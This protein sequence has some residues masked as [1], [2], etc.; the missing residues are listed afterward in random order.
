MFLICLYRMMGYAKLRNGVSADRFDS[1]IRVW[2]RLWE[3]YENDCD[4]GDSSRAVRPNLYALTMLVNACQQQR[5]A[6][7]MDLAEQALYR[8][9]SYQ[10][11]VALA[12]AAAGSGGSIDDGENSY[13]INTQMI[14]A[15]LDG[16]QKSGARDAGVR[17]EELL[18]WM[19]DEYKATGDA[20]LRPNAYSFATAIG[21]WARSRTFGK[22]V[23]AASLLQWMQELHQEDILAEPPN[24]YCYTGVINA[25]AYS[26]RDDRE[27]KHALDIAIQTYQQLLRADTDEPSHVTFAAFLTALRNLAPP[28]PKR[29]A[30][31]Q[32]V[33]GEAVSR[34]QVCPLVLKRLQ[35]AV[36]RE[37]VQTILSSVGKVALAQDDPISVHQIPTYWRRN[38]NSKLSQ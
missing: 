34:G 3:R 32:K 9:H 36:P 24:V 22:A 17:A 38:V 28:S 23:R 31:V 26:E 33:F 2:E 15:V 4:D 37:E 14:T 6:V 19:V 7:A 1:I 10:K 21:A 29:D 27:S 18:R 35:A 13:H 20:D 11:A 12:E 30:A 8:F 25:C 16:W 5:T